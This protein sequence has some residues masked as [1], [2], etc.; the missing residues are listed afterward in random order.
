MS[1]FIDV[2]S[3]LNEIVSN[4]HK[5]EPRFINLNDLYI[6][7]KKTEDL[8]EQIHL[9][10]MNYLIGNKYKLMDGAICLRAKIAS[11]I[12]QVDSNE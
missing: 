12:D 1:T 7:R 3:R 8:I 6:L 2:I 4:L 5:I 10:E 11:L 9:S